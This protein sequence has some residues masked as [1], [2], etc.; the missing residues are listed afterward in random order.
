MQS[1]HLTFPARGRLALFPTEA[2]RRQALHRLAP[3]VTDRA[4]LFCL[5][6]DHVHLVLRAERAEAGRIGQ[7]VLF[8]LRAVAP[9]LQRAHI[10]PVEGRSHL[11]WRV[12]YCL[13]QPSHHGLQTHPALYSG[14]CLPDLLGARLLPGL[15]L[16]LHEELPRLRAGEL[17]SHVGLSEVGLSE[18]PLVEPDEAELRG[19]GFHS[20][21]E[22]S[23]AALALDLPLAGHGPLAVAAR[24]AVVQLSGASNKSLGAELQVSRETL[25][26]YRLTDVQPGL[27]RAIGRQLALRQ[28]MAESAGLVRDE[29]VVYRLA[30][31]A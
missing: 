22:V 2:L 4:L 20:L 12:R 6:D 26:R 16:C 1:W 31:A 5:V 28:R 3:T 10:R 21:M 30:S 14:S 25:R 11:L 18:D 7:A 24:I 8:A 23:A 17:L 29:P 19:V 27:Q 13:Q 15:R 9:H